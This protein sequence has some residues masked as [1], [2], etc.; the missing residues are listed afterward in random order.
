MNKNMDIEIIFKIFEK[1][2]PLIDELDTQL[3][4]YKIPE[5]R[6]KI[7][8]ESII[9]ALS[10]STSVQTLKDIINL[11]RSTKGFK[12]ASG[13]VAYPIIFLWIRLNYC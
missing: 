8:S 13:L 2:S 4:V 6:I 9:F 1:I 12:K 3:S 5:E 7:L 11:H 10:S